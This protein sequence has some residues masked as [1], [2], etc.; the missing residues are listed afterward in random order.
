VS[1]RPCLDR[2]AS[3]RLPVPP[4]TPCH[5]LS[6]RDM[7]TEGSPPPVRTLAN[8]KPSPQHRTLSAH[9]PRRLDRLSQVNRPGFSGDQIS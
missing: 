4:V 1:S 7:W 5:A 8:L 2:L 9:E 6:H 3:A